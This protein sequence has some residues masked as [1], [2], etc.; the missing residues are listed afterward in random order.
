MAKLLKQGNGIRQFF[1]DEVLVKFHVHHLPFEDFGPVI[2]Q[3][4]RDCYGDF[5]V[6]SAYE[7]ISSHNHTGK[8]QL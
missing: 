6:K 4:H 5:S 7:M 8:S 2:I 1:L 3:W